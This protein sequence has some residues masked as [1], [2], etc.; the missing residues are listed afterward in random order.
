MVVAHASNPILWAVSLGIFEAIIWIVDP[1]TSHERASNEERAIQTA[2]Y[3]LPHLVFAYFRAC[4][5]SLGYYL[6][7]VS[8]T[9]IDIFLNVWVPYLCGV[10]GRD[11]AAMEAR[12]RRTGA[13]RALP[14]LCG[15]PPPT[16]EQ[17]LLLPLTAG[18]LYTSMGKLSSSPPDARADTRDSLR[19]GGALLLLVLYTRVAP[20]AK[21]A[22][23]AARANGRGGS[24]DET[25]GALDGMTFDYTA[26]LRVTLVL[27]AI[28]WA[29]AAAG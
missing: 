21:R 24:N 1:F 19:W 2:A 8:Y 14:P 23:S 18:A 11:W 5:R 16:L 10:R 15:R 22:L 12:L 27:S 29:W 20:E 9:L 26:A 6:P 3:A 17:T 13:V 4:P 25:A 7:L 28:A